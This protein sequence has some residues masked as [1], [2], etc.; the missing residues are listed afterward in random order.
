MAIYEILERSISPGG[1]LYIRA[2]FWVDASA[3]LA[4]A[5]PHI[6]SFHFASVQRTRRF[7]ET[8]GRGWYRLE[9]GGWLDPTA[10]TDETDMHKDQFVM[11]DV[12]ADIT[13]LVDRTLDRYALTLDFDDPQDRSDRRYPRSERSEDDPRDLLSVTTDLRDRV[14]EVP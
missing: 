10:I 4:A 5:S 3:R 13:R 6:E 2:A 14:R 9:A 8:D 1:G 11:E 12:P 7:P